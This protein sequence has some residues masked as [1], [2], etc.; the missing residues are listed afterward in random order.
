MNICITIPCKE[1]NEEGELW[2]TSA[3]YKTEKTFIENEIG[4]QK[5]REQILEYL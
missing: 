5:A 3:T 4:W 2:I 1:I